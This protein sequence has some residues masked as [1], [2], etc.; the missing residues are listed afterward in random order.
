[1]IDNA[2]TDE[3]I[4]FLEEWYPDVKIIQLNKNYGFAGGY[5]KGMQEIESHYTLILNSDVQLNPGCL[6]PLLEKISEENVGAIQPCVVSMEDKSYYEYAGAAG[7]WM[8]YLGYP[9]CRGRLFTEIEKINA[10]YNSD[11]IFWASGACMMTKTELFKNVGGFDAS[12]FAHQ[13]EIDLCW[14]IKR[15]GYKI[16]YTDESTI[17]HLGG[18]TLSYENPQ[19]TFLNFRNNLV[20]IIKNFPFSKLFWLIPFRFGLDFMASLLFLSKGKPR[21]MIAIWKAYLHIFWSIRKTIAK[22]TFYNNLIKKNS[23]GSFS[24]TGLIKKS[25]VF[26]FYLM[27]KKRFSEITS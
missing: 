3:S 4:A 13:E 11:E 19:K 25:I 22:R 20:T 12:Y 7:G 15:A 24:A 8:D 9:F 2:S 18:G 21:N 5:N 17:Y 26:Q 23:I 6:E 16:L 10:K 27:G 14:R 1:M